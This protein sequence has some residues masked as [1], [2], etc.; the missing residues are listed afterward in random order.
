MGFFTT[1]LIAAGF[2]AAN[3]QPAASTSTIDTSI[4]IFIAASLI[5]RLPMRYADRGISDAVRV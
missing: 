4:F 1:G 5:F 2:A 3:A